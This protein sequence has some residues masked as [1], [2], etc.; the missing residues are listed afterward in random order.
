MAGGHRAVAILPCSDLDQSEA[1]YRRLGFVVES[2]FGNY[3][4]LSDRFGMNL[5]LRKAEE[6]ALPGPGRN[7]FGLYLYVDDVD[8]VAD[9]VSDLIIEVGAPNQKP[10]GTYEFAIGDPDGVLVRIGKAVD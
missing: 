7:P 5:H 8:A 2:D 9:Q 3:R 1:F 4:I 10:W 6:G